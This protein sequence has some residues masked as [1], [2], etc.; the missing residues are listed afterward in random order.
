MDEPNTVRDAL[1][2]AQ[3]T[4]L[5]APTPGEEAAI[6]A[7]QTATA[8]IVSG[9]MDL[10]AL[11]DL[12]GPVVMLLLAMSVF[13]LAVVLLKIWQFWSLGAGRIRNAEKAVALFNEGETDQALAMA[14]RGR[15]PVQTVVG[16][17]IARLQAGQSPDL[18]RAE[19]TAL[20]ADILED[21]RGYLRP[22]EVIAAL[23]PLLG[24]F[25]TVLGMIDAFRALEAAGNNVDPTIL[26][27]GIWVALLTTA[28][29]IGV[30]MPVV[31]LLNWIERRIER[32]AHGMDSALSHLFLAPA[33]THEPQARHDSRIAPAAAGE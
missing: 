33:T 24:L 30:A 5:P 23:S 32:V 31:A 4:D 18:A 3:A 10:A 6:D 8:D 19:A 2:T 25:G 9:S 29:G 28:V 20:G 12:G 11:I 17:A 26:S 1:D 21:M 7:A 16:R 15:S 27:G 13:A 14:R 22:L